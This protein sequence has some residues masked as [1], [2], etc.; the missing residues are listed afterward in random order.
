MVIQ[1]VSTSCLWF[2]C[3]LLLQNINTLLRRCLKIKL[4]LRECILLLLEATTK[5][6]MRSGSFYLKFLLLYCLA[7]FMYPEKMLPFVLNCIVL[8]VTKHKGFQKSPTLFFFM[9]HFYGNARSN[10]SSFW[11]YIYSKESCGLPRHYLFI[12]TF[13]SIKHYKF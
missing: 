1:I 3:S 12:I 6:G 2:K 5:H 13:M 11:S 9:C 7:F 8:C 4:T 10:R